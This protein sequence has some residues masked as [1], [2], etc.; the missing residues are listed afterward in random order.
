MNLTLVIL[1]AGMAS[2]YGSLKQIA[3]VGPNGEFIIDYS[4]YDAIRVGF[5]KVVFIIKEE[6]L[7]FFQ[8]H[9]H[10]YRDK[11]AID[12]VFQDLPA[13]ATIPKERTKMLGTAHALLCAKESILDDF[14][15]INA[16]DFYGYNSFQ[17]I[18]EFFINNKD[19][20]ASIN[21]P[22]IETSSKNGK[23]KRGVVK[24]SNGYIV[25]T[26]ESEIDSS[27]IARS[28][29][30]NTSFPI[31][32]N[33]L[34]AVNFFGLRKNIFPFLEEEYNKFLSN[35]ITCDEEFL[36][37]QVLR[38]GIKEN[39]FKI[40]SLKSNSKWVGLTFKEDLD[41]VKEYIN[42]LIERGEYPSKLG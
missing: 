30:D 14:V 12:Y 4:V 36:L 39:K 18:K 9:F 8:E 28:I 33:D 10:K 15:I 26:I 22:F 29:F 11:I 42:L 13:I 17:I 5:K 20:Y 35:N 2:R 34:V 3:E 21:Y 24:E 23:V 31:K 7:T 1:A 16:D 37:S 25:D 40:K 19:D 41:D 6:N 27:L 32:E 38:V